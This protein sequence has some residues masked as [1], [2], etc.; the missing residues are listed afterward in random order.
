[1]L[2]HIRKN[3]HMWM[4]SQ[5]VFH[6]PLKVP[7][8]RGWSSGVQYVPRGPWQ[9]LLLW[10]WRLVWTDPRAERG[11]TRCQPSISNETYKFWI[12]MFSLWEQLEPPL[13]Y[14]FIFFFIKKKL[15]K[16]DNKYELLHLIYFVYLF[17]FYFLSIL[18]NQCC[19]LVEGDWTASDQP[20]A[21]PESWD[22][23]P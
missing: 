13:L 20:G 21:L 1:M 18:K 17:I 7:A 22:H 9:C 23:P 15:L 5:W 12:T 8:Q 16:L 11:T 6:V 10:N 3:I 2:Y 4:F 14:L 19:S